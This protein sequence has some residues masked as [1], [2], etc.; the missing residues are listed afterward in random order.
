[1]S[2]NL[3]SSVLGKCFDQN[4]IKNKKIRKGDTSR[5]DLDNWD[6]G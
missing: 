6:A 1:M 3:S 2:I 4:K 5:T